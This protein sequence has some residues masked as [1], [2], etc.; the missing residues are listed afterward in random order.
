MD[1][2][3]QKTNMNDYKT[4]TDT[5]AVGKIKELAADKICMF[6]TYEDFKMNTRPMSTSAVD[7]DGTLWFFT[8]KDSHKNHQLKYNQQVDLLYM[9]TGRHH[10]LVLNGTAQVIKDEDKAREIW[11]PLNKAW[12]EGGAEDPDLRLIKVVPTEGH[13][14]DTKNGKLVAVIKMMIAALTGQE[15][16]YGIEGDILT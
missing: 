7:D 2:I 11:N 4:L 14:W 5:E 8:E 12:F 9:D 13:Y 6:C 1:F 3:Y 15:T 16:N 10:Y